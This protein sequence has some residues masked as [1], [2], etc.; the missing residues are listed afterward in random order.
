MT[1]TMSDTLRRSTS[2]DGTITFMTEL[3]ERHL[4][5]CD[6]S[7]L[8]N[9]TIEK[10]SELLHRIDRTL[11][12]G[13]GQATTEELE[14]FLARCRAAE[15]KASYYGHVVG[16]FRWACDPRNPRIDYDP[17]VALRRPRVRRGQPKP[18]TNEQVAQALGE[19]PD[20]WLT[21]VVLAAYEGARCIEIAR[22]ERD[23]ITA[24]STRLHGKGGK[25][26]TL[27]THAEVWRVVE[28]LPAGPLAHRTDGAPADADYLS[29]SA[30]QKF[31]RIGMSGV[32]LHRFRH[33]YA[34]TQLR[35]QKF[36]GAGASIR[37]VQMNL[38][39]DSLNSTAIY[40]FASDEERADAIDSLPTFTTR[41]PC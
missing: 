11:P 29:N 12:M 7:G 10:R 33:W 31:E 23:D 13:L 17:S 24:E 30:R 16:F 39:H 28:P 27:K 4:K 5:H 6:A 20:P 38:G 3:I 21:W 25:T 19:L 36:G 1:E 32:T 15:T 8:A 41:N 18:V 34:T 35:P 37:T 9:T 26:R 2:S 40:T 22:A 14:D